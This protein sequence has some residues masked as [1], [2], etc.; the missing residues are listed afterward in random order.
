MYNIYN[1]Y[2]RY[3]RYYIQKAMI[4]KINKFINRTNFSLGLETS[5]EHESI[6]YRIYKVKDIK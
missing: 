5:L 3:N 1:M 4:Y 2:N 6:K